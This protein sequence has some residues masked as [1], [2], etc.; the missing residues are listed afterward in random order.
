MK[1]TAL[2][3]SSLSAGVFVLS[4]VLL[5]VPFR[6]A[7]AE[8]PTG[9]DFVSLGTATRLD[10]EAGARETPPSAGGTTVTFFN[11]S[12]YETLYVY[13]ADAPQGRT[14]DCN[15][16]MRLVKELAKNESWTTTVAEGQWA[17]FNSQR[18]KDGGCDLRNNQN[19]TRVVGLS[20]AK[21]TFVNIQ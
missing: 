1:K 2:V 18:T 9:T 14:I 19:E 10:V 8:F 5:L 21:T 15:A 13:R 12:K 17:W 16:S 11:G 20:E 3:C 7:A 4:G 6:I